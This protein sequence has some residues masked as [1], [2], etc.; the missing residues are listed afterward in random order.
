M[1]ITICSLTMWSLI[2]RTS[3]VLVNV[4]IVVANWCQPLAHY[5]CLLITKEAPAAGAGFMTFINPSCMK[6]K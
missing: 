5:V 2:N 3:E 6:E 4:T 1:G